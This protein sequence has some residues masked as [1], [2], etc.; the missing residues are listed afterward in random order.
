MSYRNMSLIDVISSMENT[1]RI[2][3]LRGLTHSAMAKCIGSIRQHI[4]DEARK[5]RN[6]DTPQTD[7][8]QR[9][10]QDEADRISDQFNEIRDG[11]NYGNPIDAA[12]EGKRA[13]G[14]DATVP[15]LRQASLFHAVYD[16][17]LTDLKTLSTSQWDIPLSLDQMLSYMTDRA[18]RLD[19]ALASALADAI[20]TDVKTIEKMHELQAMRDREQLIEAA[21]EI[22]LT[23]NGFGD[24]GYERAVDDLPKMIQHQMGV[25]IVESL[26]KARDQVLLRVMRS[27]R[28]SDLASIPIIEGAIKEMSDWVTEF[29][30]QYSDEIREALDA[31]RNIRT[32]EDLAA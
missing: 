11:H 7:I 24:N 23:F 8:D 31:G 6:E 3:A 2:A 18:P 28:L 14:F 13:M 17:A 25:K 4:R 9:N 30:K 5:A 26:K 15:P 12:D 27:R 1:P 20:H 32:L 16:W 21:P 29:E 19:P 22:R 10:A